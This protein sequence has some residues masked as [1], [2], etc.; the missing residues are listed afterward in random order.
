MTKGQ[1]IPQILAI[2]VIC[3]IFYMIIYE[4]VDD[5]SFLIQNNPNNFWPS[6]IRY[7]IS[8]LAQGY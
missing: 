4:A 8:N 6:F 3:C 2:A 7:V 1:R 5:I